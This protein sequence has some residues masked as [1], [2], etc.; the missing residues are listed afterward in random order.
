[1]SVTVRELAALV[2]GK[3]LGDDAVVIESACAL[4]AAQASD[5]TMLDHPKDAA[6][7]QQSKAGAAVVPYSLPACDKALIQVDDPLV[8]FA[9]VVQYL[10]GK[11][12]PA[13]TGI[14]PRAIVHPRAFI[15]ADPSI[16]AFAVVGE[17]TVIG[18]RCRLHSGTVIGKNCRLGDDVVLHPRVVV[19][20]GA[21]IGDRVVIHA[22][23]VLGA[24]GFGFRLHDGRHVKIP[25]MG[26]VIVGND[27]EIGAGTTVDR[28]AFGPTTIGAG[29]KI[30]DLVQV[31][32]NCQIGKH[33]LLDGQSGVAGS[34]VTGDNVTIAAQAGVK[35][36]LHVGT[37][38]VLG[39]KSGAAKD[40]PPGQRMFLYPPHE[41]SEAAEIAALIKRLPVMR[42]QLLRILKELNLVEE[43]EAP[44]A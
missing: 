8:A 39:V 30:A 21:N 24:D 42:K 19:Y 38:A 37:G 17:N 40:V 12:A 27:V 32:H 9:A 33:N 25:Q 44:A 5:I 13:P 23:A 4:H 10:H 15:D 2:H 34:C 22:K 16:E 41:E 11:A 7:L 35:D 36:H 20:D 26:H 43:P 18:K 6:K 28:G 31:A 3:V 1:M 29:T 14:D